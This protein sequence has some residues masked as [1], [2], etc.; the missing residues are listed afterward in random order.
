MRGMER[1]Y[2]N[3]RWRSRVPAKART[4]F[5]SAKQVEKAIYQDRAG[6]LCLA[7]SQRGSSRHLRLS[8]SCL[9]KLNFWLGGGGRCCIRSKKRPERKRNRNATSTRIRF[10][11]GR[12]RT[13]ATRMK[14]RLRVCGAM[15]RR[16]LR[17]RRGTSKPRPVRSRRTSTDCAYRLSYQAGTRLKSGMMARTAAVGT[18]RTV[19]R[20]PLSSKC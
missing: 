15:Q 5:Q 17:T 14:G 20:T 1:G 8:R 18:K 2:C 12:Y 9:P 3:H 6:C 10:L 4:V 13:D 19:G 16:Q 11:C 7:L